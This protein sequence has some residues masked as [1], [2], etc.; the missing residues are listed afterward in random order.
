[1]LEPLSLAI[2][3]DDPSLLVFDGCPGAVEPFLAGAREA[4]AVQLEQ[5]GMVDVA[6]RVRAEAAAARGDRAAAAE[7]FEQSGRLEEA[8]R[9]WLAQDRPERA[10]AGFERLGQLA[11][12]GEAWRAAGEPARAGDAYERAGDYEAAIEC[13]GAAGERERLCALLERTE[14][15]FEAAEVALA[16]GDADRAIASLQ[17]LSPADP[18]Y[19][20]ACRMLAEIFAGRGEARLA[21]GR[22]DDAV[23]VAAAEHLADLQERRAGLLERAG[24]LPEA[25]EALE[26]ARRRDFHRAGIAERIDALRA[27]LAARERAEPATRVRTAAAPA[28]AEEER[29]EIQGELGRGGMGIVHR[30][31]DRRLQRTIAL[32]RLPESLREHPK[33][34]ELFL[35]EARA[36][37]QL[38]HPNIVTVHDVDQR[39]GAYFITMECLEGAP[40]HALLRRHGR[41]PAPV[42]ARI[43]LQVCAGLAFA[44]GRGIVHR[45]I[46]TANLFMTRDKVV[47]IMDF[48]LAKSLAEVRRAGTVIGGTP[49][50]MAP[51]QAVGDAVDARADLYALGVTLFELVTGTLPWTEGDVAYHHRHSPPP[52]PRERAPDVPAAFASLI[53][54]LMAKE[55]SERPGS[56]AEVAAVLKTF[57]ARPA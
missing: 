22:L 40:L 35:R 20:D 33:V 52:D 14:A 57:V 3:L 26:E 37:A 54:A 45:D 11:Q 49:N 8:A 6:R 2:D 38:N 56:A 25:L 16:Q 7:L 34:V 42:V 17:K 4:A 10:A 21:I 43:G 1:V 55:P 24:R 32:K 30:A 47:K 23:A 27:A 5:A 29:Y 46:K 44:H 13:F 28:P 50:Y 53:L 9:A 15:W 39:D 48:G 36:A 51:E 12:A 31:F 18:R 41:F 19:V